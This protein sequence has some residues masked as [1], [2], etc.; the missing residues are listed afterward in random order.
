MVLIRIM[1][2]SYVFLVVFLFHF[3]IMMIACL[4][5]L[6]W[7]SD[8]LITDWCELII[9]LDFILLTRFLPPV[10][11]CSNLGY[12]VY[13]WAIWWSCRCS[14]SNSW[15]CRILS[16]LMQMIPIGFGGIRNG[17]LVFLWTIKFGSSFNVLCVIEWMILSFKFVNRSPH[18]WQY[19]LTF[20]DFVD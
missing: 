16:H 7:L 14:T 18:V 6:M 20:V 1:L 5:L 12:I 8:T 10:I 19:I 4:W 15:F 3:W 9:G 13:S 11:F 2:G 17:F